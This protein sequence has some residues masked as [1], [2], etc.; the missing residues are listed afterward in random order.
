MTLTCF[1]GEFEGFLLVFV[2]AIIV[3]VYRYLNNLIL[4]SLKNFTVKHRLP[5][6]QQTGYP[7]S[8]QKTKK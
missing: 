8:E 5:E 3:I 6:L 4:S 2:I 1:A 7:T